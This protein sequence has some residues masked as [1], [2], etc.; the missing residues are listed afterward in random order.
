MT[1]SPR[2]TFLLIG[3]CALLSLSPLAGWAS[4]VHRADSF[5]LEPS[6]V[7]ED[8]NWIAANDIS[9]MGQV[10]DDCFLYGSNLTLR[11]QFDDD[12]W[13]V[14]INIHFDGEAK[15]RLRAAA[16]QVLKIQGTLLDGLSAYAKTIH[17]QPEATIHDAT[18]LA[19][20]NII[21]EGVLSNTVWITATKVTI[22]GEIHGDI[23]VIA[24]D[25]VI[26][27]G[28][29]I[30]GDIYYTMNKELVLG[31]GVTFTGTMNQVAMEDY[32]LGSASWFSKHWASLQFI[33]FLNALLIGMLFLLAA[34][35]LIGH[36]VRSCRTCPLRCFLLGMLAFFLLPGLVQVLLFTKLG[37]PTAFFLMTTYLLGLY[38]GKLVVAV[39]VGGILLRRRGRLPFF[40]ILLTFV[41][42]CSLDE[43]IL[44]RDNAFESSDGRLEGKGNSLLD[45]HPVFI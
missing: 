44:N 35:R 40:R 22:K 43:Y 29:V 17:I 32:F 27:P 45:V 31:K 15:D 19:G 16:A 7:L 39:A 37:I 28:S 11:A 21:L 20:E 4:N 25:V 3:A 30:A 26:M 33:F 12:V 10:T 38:L 1:L 13:A 6:D 42:G 14:G 9:L 2:V 5:M 36:S 41:V 24:E 34:P 18:H 8:E 23:K